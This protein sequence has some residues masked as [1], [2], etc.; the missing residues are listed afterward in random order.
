MEDVDKRR[1][2]FLP[3]FELEKKSLRIQLQEK[4]RAFDILSGPKQTR[5]S[6]K[7][8][9]FLFLGTF[10]LPSSSWLLKVPIIE[11]HEINHKMMHCAYILENVYS[12]QNYYFQIIIK[13][14]LQFGASRSEVM[15]L[16]TF[17]IVDIRMQTYDIRRMQTQ[18][19]FVW[20]FVYCGCALCPSRYI[21]LSS[22]QHASSISARLI[23]AIE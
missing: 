4:S 11:K 12:Q 7:E 20:L 17:S 14:N 9:K 8:R 16:K 15:L 3:L 6:L 1:R 10:S 21:S 2:I 18:Q 19:T 23:L 22:R 13:K 5:L